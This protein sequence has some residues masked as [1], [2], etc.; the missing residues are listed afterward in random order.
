MDLDPE[1]ASSRSHFL[2]AMREALSPSRRHGET[3]RESFIDAVQLAP[4][5]TSSARGD[6]FGI[7]SES[8][9]ASTYS[10]LGGRQRLE[11]LGAW[12]RVLRTPVQFC[13]CGRWVLRLKNEHT[14]RIATILDIQLRF[15]LTIMMQ[16]H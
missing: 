4:A 11:W 16:V 14:A 5:R 15:W 13:K 9:A 6:V 1:S 10:R 8:L 12:Q 2:N 3:E 7:N